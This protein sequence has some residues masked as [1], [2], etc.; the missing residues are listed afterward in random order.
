MVLAPASRHRRDDLGF[1]AP[2]TVGAAI[3]VVLGMLP[4]SWCARRAGR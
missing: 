3:C 1:T 4:Q 2:I